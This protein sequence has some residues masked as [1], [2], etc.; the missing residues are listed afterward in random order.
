MRKG[1]KWQSRIILGL[2]PLRTHGNYYTL[3]NYLWEWPKVY[4]KRFSITKDIKERPQW[5][6]QVRPSHGVTRIHTSN[7]VTHSRK[8]T[9]AAEVLL[10]EKGLRS[11]HGVPQPGNLHQKK[12]TNGSKSQWRITSRKPVGPQDC[13]WKASWLFSRKVIGRK[14]E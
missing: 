5:R 3:S 4:Q 1:T 12:S 8:E 10:K 11:P 2:F 7:A 9:A 13:S 14:G 6:K